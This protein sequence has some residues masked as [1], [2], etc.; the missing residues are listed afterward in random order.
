MLITI[1]QQPNIPT[2]VMSG[3]EHLDSSLDIIQSML[4]LCQVSKE[5]IHQQ[6]DAKA[7]QAPSLSFIQST[8]LSQ[9]RVDGSTPLIIQ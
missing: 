5:R 1:L 2:V 9:K 3:R 4:C 6:I 7:T 8:Q